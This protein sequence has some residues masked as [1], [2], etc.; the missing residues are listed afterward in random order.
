MTIRHLSKILKLLY[1]IYNNTHKYYILYYILL[2]I[3]IASQVNQKCKISHRNLYMVI[4]FS[5][6][7]SH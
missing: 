7:Q 6:L 2:Y 5:T 4:L 1:T 3:T